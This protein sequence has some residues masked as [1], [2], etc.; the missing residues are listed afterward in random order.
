MENNYVIFVNKKLN[1]LNFLDIIWTW[2]LN[3]LNFL[4]E[5]GLELSFKNTGLDQDRKI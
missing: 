5:F 1:F 4:A 3:F 2:I